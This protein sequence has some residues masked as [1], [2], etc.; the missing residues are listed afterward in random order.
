MK[1]NSSNSTLY[2]IMYKIIMEMHAI[3]TLC[4]LPGF[5]LENEKGT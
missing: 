4:K 5:F 1:K 3:M 2:M